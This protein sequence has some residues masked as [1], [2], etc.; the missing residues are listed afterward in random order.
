[1]LYEICFIY[2]QFSKGLGKRYKSIL[3]TRNV[4]WMFF[5]RHPPPPLET[6]RTFCFSLAW[7]ISLFL[8]HV[9]EAA[10]AQFLNSLIFVLWDSIGI[11][12]YDKVWLWLLTSFNGFRGLSSCTYL[13]Y[14]HKDICILYFWNLFRCVLKI[15]RMLICCEWLKVDPLWKD[16]D[17]WGK[18]PRRF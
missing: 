16:E 13:F 7:Q 10:A 14:A 4:M 1:M 15:P 5:W 6:S 8:E 17:C 18:V 11:T 12:V 2:V 9:I 3:S